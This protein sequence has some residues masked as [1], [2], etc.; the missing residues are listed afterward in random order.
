MKVLH[1]PYCFAPDPMGGTEIYVESLAR[2]QALV[3]IVPEIAVPGVD[4]G[5]YRWSGL[6]VHRFQVGHPSLRELYGAGDP[7]AAKSFANILDRCSPDI[8]HLHASTSAV[9]ILL[10]R[11]AH[12]RGISVVFTYHTPSVTCQRGTLLRWGREICAGQME[13]TACSQCTL[14]GLGLPMALSRIVGSLPPAL[15]QTL[16]SLDLCGG[17]FT[18]LRMPELIELRHSAV[19]ALFLEVDE[20]VAVCQWVADLLVLN[21]VPRGKLHLSRQG[22]PWEASAPGGKAWKSPTKKIAFLGR[23]DPTKGVEI[24]VD[25]MLAE[26]DLPLHLDIYAI[27]QGSKGSALRDKMITRSGPDRRIQFLEPLSAAHIVPALRTYDALAVPSQW[28][29]TGPL[30]VYEAFAAG[31]PVIG[32]DLGGIAELVEHEKNGLLVEASSVAGWRSVLRRIV[33]EEGLLDRLKSGVSAPRR[34]DAVAADMSVIYQGLMNSPGSMRLS[35][36]ASGGRA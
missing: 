14:H 26:P 32:S 24:L 36:Q 5:E 21:G 15:G 6:T 25:A 28:L 29:E 7:L 31:I 20:V 27:A 1:V 3:A 2:Q 9:S 8:V 11:E 35:N 30:V 12:K 10:V 16:G 17:V 19:H 34:M 33:Q 22:L 18:T 4:C 13:R 23:W